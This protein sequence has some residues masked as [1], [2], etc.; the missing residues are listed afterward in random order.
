MKKSHTR[1]KKEPSREGSFLFLIITKH[2]SILKNAL[3][4]H[5]HAENRDFFRW[6]VWGD[7]GVFLEISGNVR[8]LVFK[9]EEVWFEVILVLFRGT[10]RR[11]VW[12][13]LDRKKPPCYNLNC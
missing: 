2:L 12:I 1:T 3:S 11:F 13:F 7:F 5:Q 8:R 4:P 6:V 9:L 10:G